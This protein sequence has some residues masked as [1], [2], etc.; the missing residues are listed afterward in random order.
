MAETIKE[1][2][3]NKFQGEHARDVL[4]L[5]VKQL[6][7]KIKLAQE[8]KKQSTAEEEE[9]YR[10]QTSPSQVTTMTPCILSK[11]EKSDKKLPELTSFVPY[12]GS[13]KKEK[14]DEQFRK[15]F[16]LFK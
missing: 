7:E 8:E 11:Q 4:L 15:F 16:E 13:L 9:E 1:E 12:L 2:K 5:S 14:D 6:E 3:L 10:A